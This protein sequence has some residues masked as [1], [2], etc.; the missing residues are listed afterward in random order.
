M[1]DPW[2]IT[3]S[4]IFTSGACAAFALIYGGWQ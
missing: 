1:Y 4:L 2:A 3:F